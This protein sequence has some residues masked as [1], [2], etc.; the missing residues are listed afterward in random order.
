MGRPRCRQRDLP[1]LC[2]RG[3]APKRESYREG[4]FQG[5]VTV[6]NSR[7]AK[8]DYS[9]L[10]FLVLGGLWAVQGAGN[11]ICPRFALGGTPSKGSR[12]AKGYFRAV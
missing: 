1:S 7:T 10:A 12:P 9:R 8:E 5:R 2:P 6:T 3:E 4:L 11:A